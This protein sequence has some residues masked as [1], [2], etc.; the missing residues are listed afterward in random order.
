MA[1]ALAATDRGE[2][3][4]VIA[5]DPKVRALAIVRP[6]GAGDDGLPRVASAGRPRGNDLS[7][8]QA[9]GPAVDFYAHP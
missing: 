5:R 3:V 7:V 9:I 4:V 2:L 6:G 1:A 8:A